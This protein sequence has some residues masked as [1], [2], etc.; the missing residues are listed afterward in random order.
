[1]GKWCLT[2]WLGS[3]N[4]HKVNTKPTFWAYALRRHFPIRLRWW[5]SESYPFV[6][7]FRLDYEDDVSRV[8]PSSSISDYIMRLTLRALALRHSLWRRTNARNVSYVISSRWKFGTKFS[9]LHFSW[10]VESRVCERRHYTNVLPVCQELTSTLR[11]FCFPL[12]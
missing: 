8:S 9:N 12:K 10:Q 7:T 1:M 2:S 3:N 4:H 6:I 5:R 11:L